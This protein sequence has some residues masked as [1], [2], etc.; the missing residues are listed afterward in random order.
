MD[1]DKVDSQEWLSYRP[2]RGATASWWHFVIGVGLALLLAFLAPRGKSPEFA[3]LTVGRISPAK[4]IAPFDF[5]VLK[6]PVEL[7]EERDRAEASVLPVLVRSDTATAGSPARLSTFE[8]ES[9]AMLA[10]LP[11]DWLAAAADSSEEWEGGQGEPFIRGSGELSRRLGVHISVDV[12]RFLFRLHARDRHGVEYRRFFETTAPAVM[13]RILAV[14]LFDA[15]RDRILAAKGIAAVLHGNEE[16]TLL[17]DSLIT[18]DEVKSRAALLLSGEDGLLAGDGEPEVEAAA[19]LIARLTAPNLL[20]DEEETARRR[21]VAVAHVPLA[22]GFVKQDELIIDRHIRV[23]PEHLDKLNSL[24]VKRAEL[25]G[26]RG[27]L[28]ALLPTVGYV[29][30]MALLVAFLMVGMAA[31]R[32]Q[33]WRDWRLMLLLTLI[34]AGSLIFFRLVPVRFGLSRQLLPAAFGALLLTILLDRGVAALGVVVLALGGGFI[35]GNDFQTASFALATGGVSI[36]ALRSLQARRDVMR[37]G[38]GVGAVSVVLVI[39]FQLAS[40]SADQS[41][42]EELGIALASALLSPMLVLGVVP[43]IEG[44]CGLSTDL[45]LLELVDLNQPLL[46]QLALKSPGTYHH[47]LMVGSLAE[48]AAREVGANPL[49]TRAGAYYHDIGK[50]E[51]KEYFIENQETGSENIHDR[52]PPSR[53]AQIVIEHVT[54]GLD[55]AAQH[56]LPPQIR[57]F[58]TEHHGRTRL[59]YFYAKAQREL[60]RGVSEASFRYPGPKPQSKETAILMLA[61]G[62]E[63]AARSLDHPSPQDLRELVEKL[64]TVRLAEGDLD[65]CPLTLREIGRAKEAFLRVLMGM[66]H[67]RIQY[68]DQPEPGGDA[69]PAAVA[70]QETRR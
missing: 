13:Q 61:D 41:L 42:W 9:A 25:A 3:H 6:S 20:Y 49:L 28:S 60:G 34:I 70:Y 8:R 33:T 39:G 51:I 62:T 65:Q 47:S 40:Y 63:A 57:A 43:L 2:P 17:L 38:L 10:G 46:R 18:P 22:K 26:E 1:D 45:T 67:Q 50:I 37:T 36:M 66:H 44:A 52:L 24:A 11:P 69:L 19:D 30:L 23:T 7:K 48:A 54:R 14:G 15:G 64:V 55:L 32:P 56:K 5:E 68:P 58:I 53:S 27:G 29:M 16:G 12:W 59:A 21:D 4:I 31:A 35:Q